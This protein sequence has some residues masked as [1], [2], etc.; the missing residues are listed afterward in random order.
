MG[1]KVLTLETFSRRHRF[2]KTLGNWIML[3]VR[4]RV[5]RNES[6]F[7]MDSFLKTEKA[8]VGLKFHYSQPGK[9]H[10]RKGAVSDSQIKSWQKKVL[11]VTIPNFHLH[12]LRRGKKTFGYSYIIS[13]WIAL[14]YSM[15]L[16]TAT[17]L[18]NAKTTV[19]KIED[20][21]AMACNWY[22]KYAK[23]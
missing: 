19:V 4:Q 9:R 23:A 2:P 20:T 16:A 12:I 22:K 13:P 14:W 18:S 1:K 17:H 5:P 11:Y 7:S 10:K 15:G 8:F 3:K 21:M 6:L